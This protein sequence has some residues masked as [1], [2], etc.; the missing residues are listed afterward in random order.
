MPTVNEINMGNL[1]D[2]P[3][4]SRTISTNPVPDN[5]RELYS[6]MPSSLDL[7]GAVKP[8]TPDIILFDND[9]L[10]I[11]VMTDLIFEDIGGQELINIA[12]ND[13][14]NGQNVIY[15]PIKNLSYVFN[16]YNTQNLV[17]IQDT[18]DF[19]FKNF[20]L[21]LE[22]YLPNTGSGAGGDA[23]YI[24]SSGNLVIDFI[25]I[26]NDEQVEIEV[27]NSGELFDGTIY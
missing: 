22:N 5:W 6:G 4:D 25:N 23:V 17:P 24:D 10:P 16:K 9:A 26:N 8:A 19:Y 18:S 13:L 11:E 20:S 12:R 3:Y 2:K 14:V 7:S 21:R 15:Q 27:L 1:G